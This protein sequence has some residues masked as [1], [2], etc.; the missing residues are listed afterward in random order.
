M[1]P[2]HGKSELCSKFFPTWY[3]GTFPHRHVILTSATGELATEFSSASLDLMLEYGRDLFGVQVRSDKRGQARWQLAQG[4][5]LRAAGVGTGIMGRGADL[6]IVDDYFKDHTEA[7]SPATR[8]SIDQWFMSTSSTRLSPQGAIVI[9]ATRW[10]RDDLIGRRLKAQ[11]AGGDQ[12]RVVDF[13]A[14]ADDGAAL[15]PE[16]WPLDELEAKRRNYEVTGYPWM[17]E[18][19]YQGKPPLML[20][21]EFEGS[22]LEGDDLYFDYWPSDDE[23]VLRVIALDPSKGKN[24]RNDFA[25]FA[26]LALTRDGTIYVDADVARRDSMGVVAAALRLGS[27]FA[28]LDAFGVEVNQMQE[29]FANLI[30]VESRHA[31]FQLP[32]YHIHNLAAKTTRIRSL[33]PYLAGRQFRFRRNSPGVALLIEQLRDFPNGKHDDAP[34]ALAQGL[35]LLKDL[36]AGH[37]G[38]HSD[39]FDDEQSG[40][41]AVRG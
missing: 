9:I 17:W 26:L 32:T 31:G 36:H 34:D 16:Q 6:L 19:L 11:A 41:I 10:H 3:L 13:P 1:P 24:E 35:W 29:L 2:R 27:E 12:W 30:E 23:V 25:A 37:V 18:A 4:G 14:I 39:P 38:R 5:S 15:W 21:A 22:Y 20:D 33:T 8:N 28:P 7:L 40:L